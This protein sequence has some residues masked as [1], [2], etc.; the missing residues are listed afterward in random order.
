[1]VEFSLNKQDDRRPGPSDGPRHTSG[2][3]E[4]PSGT[5]REIFLKESTLKRRRLLY[6][7]IYEN[8]PDAEAQLELFAVE[9]PG[10]PSAARP[11]RRRGAPQL[12]PPDELAILHPPVS[13]SEAAAEAA[14]AEAGGGA[15]E[16]GSQPAP[17]GVSTRQS[18]YTQKDIWGRIPSKEPKYLVGCSV[19]GRPVSAA[20][21]APH[22]DKCMGLGVGA[23]ASANSNSNSAGNN[24]N[25]H[26]GSNGG[27]GAR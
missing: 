11:E 26:H 18:S 17:P 14:T 19:C 15:S 23:R 4:D 1:M 13:E 3:F 6:P 7:D 27:G 24:G 21:F 12:L 2:S 20:R 25:S 8:N 5:A 22:L 10:P 16:H 9:I